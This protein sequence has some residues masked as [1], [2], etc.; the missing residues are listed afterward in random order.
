MRNLK[1]LLFSLV[2]IGSSSFPGLAWGQAPSRLPRTGFEVSLSGSTTAVFGHP[3]RIRG[4]AYEVRGLA[5]LVRLP[6]ARVKARYASRSKTVTPG[7]WESI[8]ADAQG[9]FV[10]DV[11][12]PSGARDPSFVEITIGPG[13]DERRF[14]VPLRLVSPYEAQLLTDRLIY[15]PGETVNVWI[16][17]WDRVTLAP[18]EDVPIEAYWGFDDVADSRT[19]STTASGVTSF[20]FPLPE[21]AREGVRNIEVT[22]GE[23]I[24]ALEGRTS[25]RVDRRAVDRLAARLE[26]SPTAAAPEETVTAR[27]EVRTPSGAPVRGAQVALIIDDRLRLSSVDT[28]S[29]GVAT[30]TFQAPAF[31]D[32]DS[33]SVSV[34]GTVNHPAHGST[35]IYGNLRVTR[36]RSLAID[37]V[38]PHGGL[39]P[40]INDELFISVLDGAGE[41]PPPG[42]MVEVSGHAVR[43]GRF[44]R[45]IDVHGF[46]AVPTRTPLNAVAVPGDEQDGL[47]ATSID[48]SVEGAQLRTAHLSIPVLTQALVAPVVAHPVV[49]PGEPIEIR[50]GRRPSVARQPIIV[51]LLDEMDSVVETMLVNPG[52]GRGVLTAPRD[53]LGLFAVRA[54]PVSTVGAGEGAGAME[55]VIVRP[56]HPAFVRLEADRELYG[57]RE[58]AHITVHT[59]SGGGSGW[60]ALLTR[61]LSM[62]GGERSFGY[63]FLRG[64]FD[65]AV[66]DPATA[67][68]ALLVR[69]ALA[70]HATPDRPPALS[71]PLVDE[72]GVEVDETFDLSGAV[73]RGDLRDPVARGEEL[74]RRGVQR[75]MVAIEQALSDALD[76]GTVEELVEGDGARR[77]FRSDIVRRVFPSRHPPQT[78]GGGELTLEVLTASDPSFTFRAVSTRVARRR[79]VRLLSTLSTYLDPVGLDEERA[80]GAA[81]EPPEW[82]LSRLVQGGLLTPQGLHDPWGRTFVVRR[83]GRQPS[84]SIAV[85]A[86]GLE[87]LSP[88]PDGIVG[89][90]DDVRNPFARVV[91]PGTPYALAC[92]EDELMAALSTLT[93]GASALQ[94]LVDAY[95]RLSDA[96]LEEFLGDVASAGTSEHALGALFGNQIGDN[97]G[98]GGLGLRGTGRGGGG[99]GSGT[100]GLGNLATI[101]HG[102]GIGRALGSLVRERFP[103]TLQFIAEEALDP[104]GQTVIE[105]E[106]ADA[107]TT[108]LVEAIVWTGEGWVWSGS[109]TIRVDQELV[110]DA[111]VPL[112]ATV[113]DQLRLPLRVSTRGK[114]PQ[115]VRLR[116][117]GSKQLGLSPVVT[118][119]LVVPGADAREVPVKLS[120]SKRA[121][122][123]IIVSAHAP[124]GQ[125]LDATKRP[126]KIIDDA[127]RVRRDLE[128]IIDGRGELS[129]VVPSQAL[130]RGDS[131]VELAIGPA[132]F[133]SD[134]GTDLA[135]EA[136]VDAFGG[137]DAV[138]PQAESA[139]LQELQRDISGRSPLLVARSVGA[140]WQGDAASDYLLSRSIIWLS[141]TVSGPSTENPEALMMQARLLLLLVPAIRRSGSHPD[142]DEQL[143]ELTARI[144]QHLEE[145]AALVT[146]A[147]WLWVHIAAALLWSGP[148]G[149]SQER[150]VELLR[151]VRR[152]V[153]IVGDDVWLEG[154]AGDGEEQL[155]RSSALLALCDVRRGN[156]QEA[157]RLVRTAARLA[158]TDGGAILEARAMSSDDRAMAQVAALVLVDGRRPDAVTLRI[159]GVSQQVTLERG[160]V[161]RPVA[162]LGHPGTHRVEVDAPEGAVVMLRLRTE[163]ALPW[164]LRPAP[165]DRGPLA[166]SIEGEAGALDGRARLRLVARNVVPRLVSMPVVEVDLPAG[167]EI[168][169]N[170]RQ[171]IEELTGRAP[172]FS[173]RTLT[174]SLPPLCPGA[175]TMVELPIRWSVAGELHGLGAVGYAA[176]RPEAV[177]VLPSRVVTIEE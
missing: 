117:E 94:G 153:I 28:D 123:T 108:Y 122:G 136:W 172:D 74:R 95:R 170:A 81:A 29:S 90:G 129:L 4:A 168:D 176:D 54:R 68:G 22:I 164:S 145:G 97:F 127:R 48:V 104:S 46:V 12:I 151:R 146:D 154:G 23:G 125:G 102:G 24:A 59:G 26:I 36:P 50:I 27:V 155:I 83:T 69:A 133:R 177:S 58:S 157:F 134:D 121:Q 18:A 85:E 10:V 65:Q 49:S 100:I 8:T 44:R 109:T 73:A 171:R 166:L 148:D 160:A 99:S 162:S 163:Y 6:R 161:S 71:P 175:S 115:R 128:T 111:P 80:R 76:T 33:S 35:E 141:E 169:V 5:D 61:D 101:G 137:R 56:A 19:D 3:H 30:A 78:L 42:T 91:P 15:E 43:G 107:I 152:S 53:R 21:T 11:Q 130:E 143:R 16:R 132:L 84:V 41:P 140:L 45:A 7:P 25:F 120:F 174:V 87:L 149:S 158:L 114:A 96:A 17:V 1:V 106:L 92:G 47:A 39:I 126:L 52:T 159:D 70:A 113:G 55:V 93:P 98:Y 156:R 38:V 40:E 138:R 88:G 82:W 20:S 165:A 37:F 110:V 67:E 9:R 124:D 32:S 64:A 2:A 89:N 112:F 62:H 135:W 142:L 14:T 144:R 139:A 150:A 103:A 63:R 86:A 13:N 34:R 57:I 51:E 105:L 119:E 60:V 77:R 75:I 72:L 167:A 116:A 131:A 31:L 118:D 66:L 79:L 173:G 147:P